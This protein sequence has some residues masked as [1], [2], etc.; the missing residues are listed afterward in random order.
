VA[1]KERQEG[2]EIGIPA[3][4]NL[5]EY[6]DEEIVELAASCWSSLTEASGGSSEMKTKVSFLLEALR[7]RSPELLNPA[8]A[9]ALTHAYACGRLTANEAADRPSARRKREPSAEVELLL[10]ALRIAG[11]TQRLA[12]WVQTPIPALNGHTPYQLIQS[13]QGR[14]EVDA[15][16]GRIEH[17]VY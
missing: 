7:A 2:E 5:G 13:E 12:E 10:K 8:F 15:V 11:S 1:E 6:T 14:K 3:T 17:G 4:G 16:L 9:K